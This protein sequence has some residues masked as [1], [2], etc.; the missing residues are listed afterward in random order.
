MT[1]YKTLAFSYLL[2]PIM[3]VSF[4][5]HELFLEHEPIQV[6]RLEVLRGVLF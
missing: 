6:M 3:G 2:L 5:P 1:S 4:L